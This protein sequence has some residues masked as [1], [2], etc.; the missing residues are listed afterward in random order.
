[1]SE[2]NSEI[3]KFPESVKKVK[4]TINNLTVIGFPEKRP[5]EDVFN[6]TIPKSTKK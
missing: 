5:I 2:Y 6:F 3:W 4:I 1:M